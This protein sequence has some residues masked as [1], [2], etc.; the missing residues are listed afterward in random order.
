LYAGVLAGLLSGG[1]GLSVTAAPAVDVCTE[2]LRAWTLGDTKRMY[3]LIDAADKRDIS[4]AQ[5]AGAFTVRVPFS[6]RTYILRPIRFAEVKLRAGTDRT[7]DYK[8]WFTVQSL[9][10]S[11]ACDVFCRNKRLSL[12]LAETRLARERAMYILYDAG[13]PDSPYV[14]LGYVVQLYLTLQFEGMFWFLPSNGSHSDS[15]PLF[16]SDT[17]QSTA[18][19]AIDTS[20]T[21]LSPWRVSAAYAAFALNAFEVTGSGGIRSP[22]VRRGRQAQKLPSPSFS[23]N[24]FDGLL[25]LMGL[26]EP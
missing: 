19:I 17:L 6:E 8:V 10:G 3:D 11:E 25:T 5:F 21:Q 26:A 23:R 13:N 15:E 2:Y 7:V 24:G 12:G 20:T 16:R 4:L 22:V 1:S 18:Q 9:L 14:N